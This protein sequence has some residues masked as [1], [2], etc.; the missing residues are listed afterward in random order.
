MAQSSNVTAAQAE[1]QLEALERLAAVRLVSDAV[2]VGHW[3]LDVEIV[4]G[5]TRLLSAARRWAQVATA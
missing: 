2:V 4:E 5:L 3:P 1:A